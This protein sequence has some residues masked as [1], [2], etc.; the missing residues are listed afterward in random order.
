V[1]G[2][3]FLVIGLRDDDT[4]ALLVAA[5][6][7]DAGP[8]VDTADTEGFTRYADTFTASDAD[9]AEQQARDACASE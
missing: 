1:T 4:G 3:E 6:M 2:R 5:V 9:D 8:L 7:E